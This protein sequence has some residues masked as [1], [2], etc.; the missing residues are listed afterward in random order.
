MSAWAIWGGKDLT[1]VSVVGFHHMGG[2]FAVDE[3]TL[4]LAYVGSAGSEGGGTSIVCC[5]ALPR[6]WR[7][8][9]IV[10]VRWSLND[11]RNIDD[12]LGRKDYSKSR[13]LGYYRAN[14]Q[15]EP[16]ESAGYLYVHFFANNKVR[17]V[18]SDTSPQGDDHP[19]RLHDADA[20]RLA[21][22]GY[23]IE[24]LWSAAEHTALD[25]R[26]VEDKRKYGDW[27]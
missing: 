26:W 12:E 6:K 5:V 13:F 24:A 22:Q 8:G 10:D 17:I 15:V 2:D 18:S 19:V 27:R 4:D 3:F 1:G 14:V 9:L 23:R 21:T 16:Y 11:L 7:P 25:K 20:A